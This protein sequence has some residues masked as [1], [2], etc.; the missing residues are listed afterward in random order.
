MLIHS[1]NVVTD[2]LVFYIDAANKRSNPQISYNPNLLNYSTWTVG[3][4]SVGIFTQNGTTAENTRAYATDP[5]GQSS[6]IW[7][8]P[9]NDAA[10]DPDG[11]WDTT[12]IGID[13]TKMYRFT[14]WVKRTV[15][16]NGT[17]Y[18]GTSGIN[19][20]DVNEGLFYRSDGV[21]VTNCYFKSF[22]WAGFA[23]NTWYLVVGHIWPAGSGIGSLHTDSGVY[24]TSGTKIAAAVDFVWKT[25]TT[26]TNHRS[27]LYY[28]TDTTTSQH[29]SH[30]SIDVC[31]GNEVPLSG[32]LN[33]QIN[34][35]YDL[36]ITNR[37]GTLINKPNYSSVNQGCLVFDGVNDFIT[38]PG[39]APSISGAITMIVWMY[40]VAGTGMILSNATQYG[41]FSNGRCWYWSST[42]G[43]WES[44][45][46]TV[47]PP[48]NIWC[49]LAVTYTP[50]SVTT[51]IF[52]VNSIANTSTGV[53]PMPNNAGGGTVLNIGEYGYQPY[54]PFNGK[55]GS[56]MIYNR[57]LSALEIQQNFNA[58]RGRYSI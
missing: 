57:V 5:F 50:G 6:I 21:N 31:D 23:V 27:Y 35:L 38:F 39:T 24:S 18:F 15:I 53:T 49:H 45:T 11:G 54:S 55:I 20:S 51:P 30:P 46:S 8:T 36:T 16:G 1:P 28:S 34:K 22:T 3:S 25:T 37:T 56:L 10:S 44:Y 43:A 4:G 47:T 13:P 40:K 19:S 26:Q 9:S 17:F 33:N 2:G 41:L 32:L 52:Y 29:W 12:R 58:T 14:T 42:T 48:F 7:S